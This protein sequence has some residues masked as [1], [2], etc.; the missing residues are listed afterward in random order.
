[1]WKENATANIILNGES[2][3]ACFLKPDTQQGYLLSLLLFSIVLQVLQQLGKR[4]KQKA[5]SVEWRRAN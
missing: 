4:K 5:L 2:F 1:M 3:K